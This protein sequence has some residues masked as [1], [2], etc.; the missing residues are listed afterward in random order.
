MLDNDIYVNHTSLGINTIEGMLS[1]LKDTLSFEGKDLQDAALVLCAYSFYLTKEEI[2]LIFPIYPAFTHLSTRVFAP[3]VRKG[4][5]AS[6][7]ATARKDM[8]GTARV[9]Y[10]VTSQGYQYAN[11]LCQGKLTTRYKK[12]RAR[13]AKSHTYYIGYNFIQLLMLGFPMIWQKEYLLGS[14]NYNYS[15]RTSALQVDAYCELYKQQ[16]QKPFFKVYIEQDLRTEHNDILVGKLQNYASY[17]LMDY[18]SDSMIIFSMSQKGVTYGA[19]GP[20]VTQHPYS[21]ARVNKILEYMK[22]MYLDDLY[23]A[24]ITGYPDKKFITSFM[25]KV[26]AAKENPDGEILKRGNIRINKEFVKEFRDLINQNRNPY[27]MKEF[28]ITRTLAARTRLEEMVKLVYKHLNS[29]E[30]FL[31]KIRRG[32][33]I[34]YYAT[35]LVADRI[36]YAKLSVFRPEQERL[37]KSLS[38]FGNPRF[39]NE[40]SEPI[41][42]KKGTKLNLRNHFTSDKADIYV[43]FASSDVGAWVRGTHFAKTAVDKKKKVLVLIFETKQQM[44]DFYRANDCYESEFSTDRGGIVNLMLY[45]IGTEDK[46]F[47]VTD[48]SLKRHYA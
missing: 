23:D 2:S 30:P 14:Y 31:A 16:E 40:L 7:Q 20:H 37:E 42:L 8:E 5:L 45:D 26:G 15:N 25:L 44:Q 36:K 41:L 46:L 43:E 4:Y 33:Q 18:P 3:L 35:T 19:N 48:E 28:N 32:Y 34:C 21:E 12:N 47:Y 13:I 10:Y 11:S 39:K 24:Y 29:N 17:G 27:A 38:V 9:F 1:Y 22:E 6:E